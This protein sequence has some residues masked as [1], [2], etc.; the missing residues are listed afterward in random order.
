MSRRETFQKFVQL[1]S[2]SRGR[3]RHSGAASYILYGES[4]MKHT[5]M[6]LDLSGPLLES[7]TGKRQS[8]SSARSR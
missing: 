6:R 4:R 2:C 1:R 5:T 7:L 3:W 8:F